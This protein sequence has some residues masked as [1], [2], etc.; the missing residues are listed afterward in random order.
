MCF[1]GNGAL[2]AINPNELID[3]RAP[4]TFGDRSIARIANVLYIHGN[5]RDGVKLQI[6][7]KLCV[8]TPET[9]LINLAAAAHLQ[10]TSIIHGGARFC[11]Y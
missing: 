4:G 10:I 5:H 6:D 11:L 9:R 2:W 1:G 3:N 7:A 8:F